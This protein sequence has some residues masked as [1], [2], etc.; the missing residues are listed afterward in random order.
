MIGSA[1]SPVLV[2]DTWLVE[3]VR[4]SSLLISVVT[5]ALLAKLYASHKVGRMGLWAAGGSV[6]MLLMIAWAQAIIIWTGNGNLVPINLGV[7]A[8]VSA[9]LVGVL[10]SMRIRWPW[11]DDGR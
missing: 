7:L 2:N 3:V 4:G 9:M 10:Q 5:A 6:G 1:I 11:D 8:S